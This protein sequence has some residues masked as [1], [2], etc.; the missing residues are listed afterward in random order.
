MTGIEGVDAFAY[1]WS[2]D[3]NWLVSPIHYIPNVIN[4]ML[5]YRCYGIFVVPKWKSAL[6][7][8]CIVKNSVNS[9][10]SLKTRLNMSIQGICS[11]QV[12]IKK[13]CLLDHLL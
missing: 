10:G 4:H 5:K 8:P 12:H 13:V 7:W 2:N 3:N 1:D 6:F 11:K 9:N